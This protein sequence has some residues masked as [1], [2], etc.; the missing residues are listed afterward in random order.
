MIVGQR[1]WPLDCF[2]SLAMTRR[3]DLI[4]TA[5]APARASTA[6]RT[7]QE[8]WLR[9]PMSLALIRANPAVEL[10]PELLI[11]VEHGIGDPDGPDRCSSSRA[12]AQAR[13]RCLRIG[14]RR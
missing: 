1:R 2:A 10:N 8:S 11:A 9:R 13:R 6:L 3:V 14:S 12:Q 7:N 4:E 5:L